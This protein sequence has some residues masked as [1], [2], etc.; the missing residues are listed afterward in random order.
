MSI[1]FLTKLCRAPENCEVSG[2]EHH[3]HH[4]LD[5]FDGFDGVEVYV[6][7][8]YGPKFFRLMVFVV[9]TAL[10]LGPKHSPK[11]LDKFVLCQVPCYTE[12]EDSLR[13]T[14]NLLAALNYDDICDGNLS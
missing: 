5:D 3:A 1:N 8:R 2:A 6:F 12:G 10:Q 14:I 4:I 7:L 9:L 13:R 11:L